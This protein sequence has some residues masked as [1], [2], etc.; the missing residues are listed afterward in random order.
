MD[1]PFP[2][3][4]DCEGRLDHI[5]AEYLEAADSGVLPDH[6]TLLAFYEKQPDEAKQ[7]LSVGESKL[8]GGV[9]LPH[10]AAL[11]MIANQ[12]LNLDEVLNK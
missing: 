11:T 2:A 1:N 4:D 8:D 9:S 3:A 5:L 12:L 6:T 10:L 7:F